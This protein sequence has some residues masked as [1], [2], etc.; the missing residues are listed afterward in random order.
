MEDHF[1]HG[2]LTSFLERFV[3]GHGRVDYASAKSDRAS[4]QRYIAAI[5]ATSPDAAPALFPTERDRL[6]Y[7]INAYNAWVLHVV[8]DRHPVAGVGDFGPPPAP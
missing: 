7:W 4:L 2:D 5:G 6:A 3:D 1:S 8:L